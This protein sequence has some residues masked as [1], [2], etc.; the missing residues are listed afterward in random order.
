MEAHSG[1]NVW[2]SRNIRAEF[3]STAQTVFLGYARWAGSSRGSRGRTKD[4][5]LPFDRPR[6]NCAGLSISKASHPRPVMIPAL[7]RL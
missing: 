1:E 6:P 2:G 7:L 3:C 4:C 5:S